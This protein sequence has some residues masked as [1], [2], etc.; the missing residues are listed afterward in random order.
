[1]TR[2]LTNEIQQDLIF[3]VSKFF[4]DS[5][6]I[7]AG[8]DFS[9]THHNLRRNGSNYLDIYY[10]GKK[11]TK[12]EMRNFSH[13]T[14]RVIK[15]VAHVSLKVCPPL[16][17]EVTPMVRHNSR[18]DAVYT[19]NHLSVEDS[20]GMKLERL[21]HRE[22]GTKSDSRSG[23][24]TADEYHDLYEIVDRMGSRWLD[25]MLAMNY[26][27]VNRNNFTLNLMRLDSR[28]FAREF[29]EISK[30]EAITGGE[31]GFR[32]ILGAV[33]ENKFPVYRAV[34]FYARSR[35]EVPSDDCVRQALDSFF[36]PSPM[37]HLGTDARLARNV[38]LDQ[39]SNK[40]VQLGQPSLRKMFAASLKVREIVLNSHVAPTLPDYHSGGLNF[41]RGS[42]AAA[43]M[44]LLPS[45]SGHSP[46]SATVQETY[47]Q[48]AAH[49]AEKSA[50]PITAF[51]MPRRSR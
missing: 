10:T 42:S 47:A 39:V 5:G 7:V 1:M 35:E 43:R 4:S 50:R 45:G 6:D 9:L 48:N 29:A 15:N 12:K 40:I 22:A 18:G 36:H 51:G 30:A 31:Q 16:L 33:R 11:P 20:V 49:A 13:F 26:H 25:V 2:G 8:V 44:T 38:P 28:V 19:I 32:S 46:E 37:L 27:I 17:F 3:E 14:N 34:D 24:P 41:I 23:L 21:S